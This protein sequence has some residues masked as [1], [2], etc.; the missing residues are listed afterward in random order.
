MVSIVDIAQAA[1]VSHQV[2][3][4]TLNGGG[5][6]S[7]AS[8]MTQLKIR[9][10]ARQMGYRPSSAGRA[11]RRGRY[12][13]VGLLVGTSDDF[14]L[15]EAMMTSLACGLSKAGYTCTLH[16]A[17]T[18][19][20]AA[21]F[22]NPLLA[23]VRSDCLLISYVR[24][25]AAETVERV[26]Q[27]GTPVIWLNRE[28]PENCIYVDEGQGALLLAEHLASQG[29]RQLTLVD[30]GTDLEAPFFKRRFG[31]LRDFCAERGMLLS[32]VQR[33]LPRAERAAHVAEWLSWPNHPSAIIANS[34][35]TAQ[36]ICQ[37][38]LHRGMRLPDDLAVCSFDAGNWHQ[39]NF[40]VITCAV[41]SDTEFG[42]AAAR[43]VLARLE[44]PVAPIPSTALSFTLSQGGTTR[45][46][47]QET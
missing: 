24:P 19:E 30:Y 5:S 42:A 18:K 6:S 7:A 47:T 40:P 20:D 1:G 31:A 25:L 17:Q 44:N 43:A 10:L 45:L 9:E 28:A 39:A 35:S 14:L 46:Q 4:K 15:P 16:C 37:T 32:L 38:A 12:H 22:S 34:L 29:H 3:S 23:E 13:S 27:I 26:G 33:K 2:V 8:E 21:M 36:I 11:M 41:R